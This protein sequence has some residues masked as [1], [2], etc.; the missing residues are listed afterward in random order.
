MST[1][2]H[3]FTILAIILTLTSCLEEQDNPLKEGFYA[4]TCTDGILNQDEEEIDCGGK[5]DPCPEPVIAPCASSLQDNYISTTYDE[6]D[7]LTVL[8]QESY[9]GGFKVTGNSTGG[10]F[11]ISFSDDQLPDEDKDYQLRSQL[12]YYNSEVA[13]LEIVY[14]FSGSYDSYA[15]DLYVT[16][17]DGQVLL[18]FCSVSLRNRQFDITASG[19]VIC[20]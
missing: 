4:P 2:K 8:C 3:I 15:G 6:L 17:N 16:H 13:T 10:D 11:S 5:C 18:E 14:P 12:D 7:L 20:D 9:R 19:R 1:L